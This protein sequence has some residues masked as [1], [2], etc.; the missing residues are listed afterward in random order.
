MS[1]QKKQGFNTRQIHAGYNPKEHNDS[2][3]VPIYQTA[4]FD[5]HTPER[6]ENIIK[7]E[8]QAF[9][10]TRV[11]NPTNSVLESRIAA[12]DGAKAAVSLAS[13]QAAVS[14]AIFNAGE[15]GRVIA[16]A[17]IYGGTYDGYRKLF[18][19]LGVEIDL[20]KDVNDLDEIRSLIKPDT[21]AIFIES[22]SNP[23]VVVADIEAIAGLAHENGLP[24]IVDNTLATPYLFN[25]L[26]HGADIVVYSATK[27]LSGHGSIIGGLIVE[28]GNFNWLGGRHPHFEKPVFTFGDRNVAETFPEFPFIGR[29]RTYYLSQLGATLAPF[30]AFLTLQ[31]VETL[32]LRVRQQSESALKI[33]VWLEKQPKVGKV[34]YAALESSPYK[35]LADKY[36]PKGAGGL[37][38][39][40]YNGSQEEI[41][42]FINSLELFSY[43][44]NLGDNRSLV[45]NSPKTTHHE[46]TPEELTEAGINPGTI[47]LSIGLEDV[48]DLIADLQQAFEKNIR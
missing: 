24:L 6:A 12:L 4:A 15:N 41:Y 40:D 34:N 46:L 38:S 44:A 30:N 21:R 1:T 19:N 20:L 10:Y 35:A 7:F 16:A 33:A 39:F 45:I 27:A 26:E 37:L 14:Y 9:L 31:G 28:G 43:H 42:D 18:P 32:N 22:I 8:E 5:L 48:E 36:L 47:R 13:G 25:P 11:G 23:A 3:Q 29:V 2:I 17:K